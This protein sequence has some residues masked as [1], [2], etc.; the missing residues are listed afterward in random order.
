MDYRVLV[1]IDY[2][3]KRAEAGDVV[4]D[5]PEKSIPWLTRQGLVEQ[6]KPKTREVNDANI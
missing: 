4:G 5:L 3:G 6:M 1:G 2:N